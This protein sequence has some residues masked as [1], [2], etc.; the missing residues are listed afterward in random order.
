MVAECRAELVLCIGVCLYLI[1]FIYFFSD[2]KFKGVF[3][4]HLL[5]LNM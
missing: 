4:F 3:F 5:S 1:Q 2:F